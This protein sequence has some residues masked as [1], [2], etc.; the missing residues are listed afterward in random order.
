MLGRTIATFRL[1]SGRKN[2]QLVL[3]GGLADADKA[4]DRIVVVAYDRTRDDEGI[5]VLSLSTV[6]C[7]ENYLEV[8]ALQS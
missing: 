1:V 4:E 6:N 2:R 5:L 3:K 7:L 8:N